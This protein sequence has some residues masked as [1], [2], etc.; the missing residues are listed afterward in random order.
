MLKRGNKS[1]NR[2][3]KNGTVV[4]EVEGSSSARSRPI[5]GSVRL[6]VPPQE[7]CAIS[8]G[9]CGGLA[10]AALICRWP[11]ARL[12]RLVQLGGKKAVSEKS[13]FCPATQRARVQL[14]QECLTALGAV[15]D[16][17]RDDLQI[18]GCV[19]PISAEGGV[20]LGGGARG[21]DQSRHG[22]MRPGAMGSNGERQRDPRSCAGG[23]QVTAEERD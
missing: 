13:H 21:A 16:G 15:A 9:R 6:F 23:P 3:R 4:V 17:G 22:S 20:A 8:T 12:I 11:A 19:Q 18:A 2:R 7:R 14:M 1:S 10:A 5:W